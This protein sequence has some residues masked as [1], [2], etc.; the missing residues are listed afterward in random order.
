MDAGK[1]VLYCIEKFG[2]RNAAKAKEWMG[3]PIWNIMGGMEQWKYLCHEFKGSDSLLV[4]M[5][6]KKV[7]EKF[8]R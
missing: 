7:K 4:N 8:K 3:E 1:Q 5:I 2:Y 6:N